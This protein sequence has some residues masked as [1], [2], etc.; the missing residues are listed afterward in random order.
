MSNCL[1]DS[2]VQRPSFLILILKNLMK[3]M[4]K[5]VKMEK[6]DKD[7]IVIYKGTRNELTLMNSLGY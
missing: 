4:P 5:L 7:V 3:S 2:V 6:K 1:E